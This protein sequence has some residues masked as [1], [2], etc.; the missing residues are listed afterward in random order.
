MLGATAT[1]TTV[2][3]RRIIKLTARTAMPGLLMYVVVSF[4]RTGFEGAATLST[5]AACIGIGVV[6]YGVLA[7]LVCRS[8]VVEARI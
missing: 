1:V 3:F 4:S 7:L 8:E 2:S 6:V 5:L